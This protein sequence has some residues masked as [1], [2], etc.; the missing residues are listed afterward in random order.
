MFSNERL[1]ERAS[2]LLEALKNGGDW[3]SLE[4]LSGTLGEIKDG[5][6]DLMMLMAGQGVIQARKTGD[7]VYEYRA[8]SDTQMPDLR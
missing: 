7:D 6:A 2:Q 5:D 3:V 8:Y 4:Q 1:N